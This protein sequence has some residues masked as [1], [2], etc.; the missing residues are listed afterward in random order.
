MGEVFLAYDAQL[1]RRVAIKTLAKAVTAA[2]NERLLREART[3]AQLSHPNLVHLYEA[4]EHEGE[5]F[6]VMEYIDGRSLAVWLSEGRHASPDVLA[7]FTAAGTGLAAAHRA[8]IVHR[9]FKPANVI[10]GNDGIP[11]VLDFGIA[12]LEDALAGMAAM[13][14]T[15]VRDRAAALQMT[16]TERGV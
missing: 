8:G 5:V 9:D 14:D 10:I 2:E 7:V 13:G 1:H 11:R 4:G 12:V 6:L 15:R 3:L 16:L